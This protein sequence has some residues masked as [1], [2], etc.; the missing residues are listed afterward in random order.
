V[1]YPNDAVKEFVEGRVPRRVRDG[2]VERHGRVLLGE[3]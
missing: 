2:R 1:E 3:R